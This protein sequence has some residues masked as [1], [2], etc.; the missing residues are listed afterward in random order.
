M[1]PSPVEDGEVEA[2]VDGEGMAAVQHM[3]RLGEEA[4]EVEVRLQVGMVE[5][6]MEDHGQ[7]ASRQSPQSRL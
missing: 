1:S 4:E 5:V 6:D 3:A 2:E 7:A